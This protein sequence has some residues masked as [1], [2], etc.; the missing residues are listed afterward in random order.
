MLRWQQLVYLWCNHAF[1]DTRQ[2]K[3]AC[4]FRS[5]LDLCQGNHM[6]AALKTPAPNAPAYKPLWAAVGVLGVA[7]MAMVATVIHIQTQPVEPSLAVLSIVAPV[8]AHAARSA[9]A[10]VSTAAT[11]A[12]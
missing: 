9:K 4:F 11:T 3:T 10:S 12:P 5:G 2:V 8:P 1:L 7:V 6:P